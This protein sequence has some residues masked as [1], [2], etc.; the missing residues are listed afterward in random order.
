[1]LGWGWVGVHT[2]GPTPP[3]KESALGTHRWCNGKWTVTNRRG[4]LKRSLFP[5][6]KAWSE[7]RTHSHFASSHILGQQLSQADLE[8][9]EWKLMLAC[10]GEQW[11]PVASVIQTLAGQLGTCS[12]HAQSSLGHITT[13]QFSSCSHQISSVPSS[14]DRWGNEKRIQEVYH[15]GK[16]KVETTK[17]KQNL[18]FPDNN[19][20]SSAVWVF[21]W[22][23][24]K[25]ERD[26]QAK[27]FET[28]VAH[29]V[30]LP[31]WW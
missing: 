24:Q 15:Q 28:P 22:K 13:F 25:D 1:M 11:E 29:D 8:C 27:E 4:A 7:N 23:L 18:T 2:L 3:L 5:S 17:T 21:F 16:G 20:A 26:S 6:A 9:K 10:G 14:W 19:K 12:D 31:S 30:K